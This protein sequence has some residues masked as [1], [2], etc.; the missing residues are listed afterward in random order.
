MVALLSPWVFEGDSS[1]EK[2]VGINLGVSL[3][4]KGGTAVCVADK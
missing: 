3:P 2:K 1:P 4:K